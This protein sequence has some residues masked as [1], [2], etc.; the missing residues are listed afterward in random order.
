MDSTNTGNGIFNTFTTNRYVSSTKEF[1]GSTS[2]L[3]KVSFL[4]LILFL[5]I[6]LLR[7]ATELMIYFMAPSNTPRLIDGMIDAKNMI[8]IPQ[9]P[10][11]QSSVNI[12][13]SS[14]EDEGIEFTWSCWV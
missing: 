9:N 3:A 10:S 7:L 1:L 2:L 5:F 11:I 4:L 12:P 13:R 6:V 8:V 14:N